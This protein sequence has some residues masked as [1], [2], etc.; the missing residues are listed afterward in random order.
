MRKLWYCGVLVLLLS[1]SLLW[2]H[3]EEREEAPQV[4]EVEE[5]KA[6]ETPYA[7]PPIRK[8]LTDH[9]HN[10]VVH[11]PIALGLTAVL[12][13]LLAFRWPELDR[14]ARLLVLLGALAAVVAWASGTAQEEAFEGGPKEWLVDLHENL[15]I[16]TLIGYWVWV[17]FSYFRPLKRYAWI[18]GLLLALL[19]GVTGFY[20]GLIAHG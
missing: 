11:F 3:E 18:V 12:L 2:A 16:A 10:K 14:A 20:G 15:G 4:E 17:G 8:A 1:G 6:P 13:F 7:M 5:A 9:L 19:I